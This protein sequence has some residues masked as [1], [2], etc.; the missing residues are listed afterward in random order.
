M[1]F[2]LVGLL[3]VSEQFQH[4]IEF[5][6]QGEVDAVGALL[7]ERFRR[8]GV[9]VVDFHPGVVHG[10]GVLGGAGD[11]QLNELAF[12]FNRLSSVSGHVR[13]SGHVANLN[14][15]DGF[16]RLQTRLERRRQKRLMEFA[17]FRNQF[18]G[19]HGGVR[20]GAVNVNPDVVRNAVQRFF[21]RRDFRSGEFRVEFNAGVQTP[22]FVKRQLGDRP[23]S[24]CRP[25]D[26][27]I[28]HDNHF[29]VFG[30]FDVQFNHLRAFSDGGFECW[31]RVFRIILF[32]AAMSANAAS[33][34]DDSVVRQNQRKAQKA[35]SDKEDCFLHG[36][37]WVVKISN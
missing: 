32:V 33:R 21:Q 25:V 36:G 26:G 9:E 35:E 4:H 17:F 11:C 12:V 23:G 6:C 1:R 7:F 20:G 24:V 13:V 31:Y 30:Q 10:F 29:T 37:V 14:A 16:S 22:D 15:W 27:W 5:V 28:V 19:G 18:G 3:L 2:S 8:V 34:H